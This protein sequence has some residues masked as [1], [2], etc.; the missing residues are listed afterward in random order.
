MLIVVVGIFLSGVCDFPNTGLIAK[1]ATRT[2][3]TY[4]DSMIAFDYG[5]PVIL[6]CIYL[7]QQ[8]DYWRGLFD[9]HL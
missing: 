1:K 8:R 3:K 2:P 7:W 6:N 4:I 5:H 9:I